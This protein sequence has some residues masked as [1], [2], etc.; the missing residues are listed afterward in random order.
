MKCPQPIFGRATA[1]AWRVALLLG[2]LLVAPLWGQ[3]DLSLENPAAARSQDADVE[4]QPFPDVIEWPPLPHWTI[5]ELEKIK[6]GQL[7]IGVSLFEDNPGELADEPLFEALPQPSQPGSSGDE[8]LYPTTIDESFLAAYFGGR[9]ASYLVDPQGMLSAQEQ[10]DRQSFL[11]YHAGDSEI[12]LF[13]YLFDQ[14]QHV[15]PE[16]D[17]KR[18]FKD[19]FTRGKGLTA[20]I[21]YYVGAPERSVMVMSPRVA[22]VVPPTAIR[23]ALIY[24]KQQAQAKSEPASQL[25]SFSTSLS[26]RL[27]WMEQEL[28]NHADGGELA[29][30]NELMVV[31]ASEPSQ[32]SGVVERWKA[33]VVLGFVITAILATGAVMAWWKYQRRQ[34]FHFPETEVSPLLSAPHAAGVGAVIHFGNAT[35]PPSVQKEQVPDYLRRM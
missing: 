5:S 10:K 7:S 2:A 19:H 29:G 11:D 22:T 14:K 8:E 16:G 12:D 17:I 3:D 33:L 23:G 31:E 24:A 1:N 21:Y 13:I 26:L 32:T 20:L 6:N 25:E 35:L 30:E 9:P 34:R 18:V 27:Y 28:A 15:P 4:E